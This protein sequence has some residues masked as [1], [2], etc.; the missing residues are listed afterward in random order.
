MHGWTGNILI[1]DLTN[2]SVRVK[3][4]DPGRYHQFI[5]GKGLAG[6]YLRNHIFRDW[7]DP[8]MPLM[9][10]TGPLVG[11]SAPTSGRMTV[12]SKS[13]LTG[14]IGDASVGGSFGTELKKAG[15]DG[16]MVYGKA[17][18]LTGIEITDGH[19]A[20]TDAGD[21]RRKRLSHIHDALKKKGAHAAVGP[22]AENGV[23]FANI[24]F[25]GHYAAG[26][27]GLGLVFA[28]KNLKYI[29]VRGHG[30]VTVYDPEGL[31]NARADILRL[32]AASPAVMGE[33]GITHY[34]TAAL[35]DLT[36]SRRMMPT[37][38]F[39][40]TFFHGAQQMNAHAYKTR[41]APKKT[42]CRGCHIQCKKIADT[43]EVLP[44][45]E[46]MNHFSAL[47]NNDDI[48]AVVRANTI[49]ND[50]GMDT[51]SAGAT[52]ACHMEI[53]GCTL[54]GKNI[55]NLLED[56]ALS[57]GV[58]EELKNGSHAYAAVRNRPE[59]SMTVKKQ[60]LPA[61]DPRGAYGMALGYAVSTRGGCHLRAYTIGNEV[62]RKPVPTD[63]FTFSGK[64]RIVKI[65]EDSN[66]VV[67]SLTAC[68]FIF[69]GATLEEYATVYS[70][71]TGVLSSGH[72][73]MKIGERIVYHERM[74]NNANGFTMAE[75][76]LPER[77]F[78]EPGSSS[79]G[80]T[81][82]ALSRNEFLSARS[83]Y[84]RIRGLDEN[85]GPVKEKA[86][87]LGLEWND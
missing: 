57:R 24:M 6:F 2:R 43:E 51:I 50:M 58:G 14:T 22:A 86:K 3:S 67:D 5:G 45:F 7:D 70:A 16:I 60:E 54:S 59:A 79:S 80:I 37:D 82:N 9:L 1:L 30:K 66:A 47:L 63:R 83:T 19:I 71:V 42:G 20:F 53:T 73:L 35:F 52:L 32:A 62:L 33:L 76:D 78:K 65:A 10:F 55:C 13:P 25:D 40:K 61:Y 38:N 17:D 77:F 29:T 27:N 44:E 68:K 84:Y 48:S 12:I 56:I 87:A 64:A 26:R 23:R 4:P 39:R 46:T 21:F 8:Q 41:Y 18:F 28:A 31:K 34:G 69:F 81:V 11:T 72:D 75:D 74:L 49:C 36:G 85:G 15:F